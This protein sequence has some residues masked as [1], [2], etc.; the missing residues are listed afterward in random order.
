MEDKNKVIKGITGIILDILADEK[1]CILSANWP[2]LDILIRRK[3]KLLMKL[4]N[5]GF[6][7]LNDLYV[8]DPRVVEIKAVIQQIVNAEDENATLLKVQMLEIKN[9]LAHVKDVLKTAIYGSVDDKS[10]AI[11]RQSY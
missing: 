4:E 1:S 8:F 11:L 10:T 6:E 9:Q 5:I 2:K 3:S 7:H